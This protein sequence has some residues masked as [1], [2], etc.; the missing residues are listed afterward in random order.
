M[1]IHASILAWRIPWTEESG[2]LLS[3]ELQRV[4]LNWATNIWASLVAQTEKNLPANAGD[5]GSMPGLGRPLKN[6]K[7]TYSSILGR[8]ISWTEEPDGLRLS[9]YHL[10]TLMFLRTY[11]HFCSS[12]IL[13]AFFLFCF[14]TIPLCFHTTKL[15]FQGAVLLE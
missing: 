10:V 14:P 4:G 2:G 7:T 13:L 11:F 3:K 5:L 9:D 15:H 1:A 8:R 6:G 12:F